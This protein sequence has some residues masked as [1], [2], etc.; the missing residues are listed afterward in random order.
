MLAY[1]IATKKNT[2]QKKKKENGL[3]KIMAQVCDNAAIVQ[4]NIFIISDLHRVQQYC[5]SVEVNGEC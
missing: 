5:S 4:E 2:S 3:V 1:Y